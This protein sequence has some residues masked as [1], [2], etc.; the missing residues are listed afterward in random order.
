[1]K[2]IFAVVLLT[3]FLIVGCAGSQIQIVNNVIGGAGQGV[4][5]YVALKYPAVAKAALPILQN[6]LT[7]ATGGTLSTGSLNGELASL[8]SSCSN[9]PAL[10]AAITTMTSSLSVN[11]TVPQSTILTGQALTDVE[12]ALQGMIKGIQMVPTTS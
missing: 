1:M 9:D 11:I 12:D 8:L 4:G 2:N 10:Q 7:L 3:V 5:Q 6:A